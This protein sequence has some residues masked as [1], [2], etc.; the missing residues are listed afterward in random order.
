MKDKTNKSDN[1]DLSNL[2]LDKNLILLLFIDFL[3][4]E[5]FK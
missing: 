3:L 1:A 5:L 4:Y 2:I